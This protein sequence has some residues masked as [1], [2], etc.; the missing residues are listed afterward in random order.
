MERKKVDNESDDKRDLLSKLENFYRVCGC[1]GHEFGRNCKLKL[2]TGGIL[3]RIEQYAGEYT[4]RLYLRVLVHVRLV[5]PLR[6]HIC[7]ASLGT[8]EVQSC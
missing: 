2:H 7:V 1:F 6:S 3:N 8:K 4:H 5:G